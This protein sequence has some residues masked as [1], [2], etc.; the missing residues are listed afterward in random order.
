MGRGRKLGGP[1]TQSFL[2]GLARFSRVSASWQEKE[3][4]LRDEEAG[5]GRRKRCQRTAPAPW[6]PQVL[7]SR[8][9]TAPCADRRAPVGADII[10]Q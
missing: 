7:I 2:S 9:R 10:I 5:D 4:A 3:L 1:T 6:V 8:I